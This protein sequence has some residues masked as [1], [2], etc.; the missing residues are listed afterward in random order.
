MTNSNQ[1]KSEAKRLYD[2]GTNF[3]KIGDL[4]KAEEAYRKAIEID[5]NSVL[6]WTDLGNVLAETLRIEEAKEAYLKALAIDPRSEYAWVN[7]GVL[8]KQIENKDKAKEAYLKAIEID[9]KYPLAWYNLGNLLM[10]TARL[11]EAEE[12]FRKVINLDVNRFPL[13]WLNL[14]TTYISMNRF[15][16]AKKAYNNFISH[17]KFI[18]LKLSYPGVWYNLGQL[19]SQDEP[20]KAARFFRN[21]LEIESDTPERKK[22]IEFISKQYA[23]KQNYLSINKTLWCD[24]CYGRFQF[25]AKISGFKLPQVVIVLYEE[26]GFVNIPK[27]LCEHCRKKY[28]LVFEKYSHEFKIEYGNPQE[29]NTRLKDDILDMFEIDGAIIIGSTLIEYTV[30]SIIREEGARRAS[31][32]AIESLINIL[33][34]YYLVIIKNSQKHATQFGREI[35]NDND[36]ES[37]LKVTATTYNGRTDLKILRALLSSS[38]TKV[39]KLFSLN[40]LLALETTLNDF[41]RAISK[42]AIEIARKK[43]RKTVTGSDIRFA[44]KQVKINSN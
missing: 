20:K 21:Y 14:G 18:D 4:F 1:I 44:Y 42:S 22:I 32:E 33:I 6:A 11:K 12:A 34:N 38:L 7:F 25:I 19:Y 29:W 13:A 31:Y 39:K 2:Q 41:C 43:G 35:V 17:D 24:D 16:E 27:D 9:P 5:P 23:S 28:D 8:Y 36:I 26:D 30:E 10:E 37:T 3:I 15:E 40:T